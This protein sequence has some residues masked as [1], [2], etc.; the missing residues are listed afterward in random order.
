MLKLH[1]F[2]TDQSITLYWEKPRYL[3]EEY[4]FILQLDG[5]KI[6]ESPKTHFTIEKLEAAS[7]YQ[8]QL[9]LS[10]THEII[11]TS[12]TVTIHTASKKRRIDVTKAPYFAVGDGETLNTSKLQRAIDDC[13]SDSV[14]YI[15]R[16]VFMTGA[17][18]LHSDMELYLATGAVLQG[19]VH[20]QDY[21]PKIPSRFEG[22]EMKCYSSLLN[23]GDLN[24]HD[25]YNCENILIHGSGSIIGGGRQLA[26]NVINAERVEL[27]DLLSHMNAK[28]LNYET[29]DT[30]PGRVRPRLVNMSNCQNIIL[31]G[32]TLAEGACWNVHMIYSDNIITHN[33]TI[34]SEGIWNGDGWN[35]DSSTNCSIFGTTFYTGDDSIAIK[36]GK[37]PEGNMIN[38]PCKHIR[39]FD[40]TCM[41]GHGFAIGSEM[42]GGVQDVKIWD[43]DLSHT[44]YGLEIKGTKK[45]GS[46]VKDVEVR[47]CT[48]SRIMFHAVGYN[49]DG[50][51]AKHPPLFENCT[52]ENLHLL[53]EYQAADEPAEPCSAIEL[54]G[55]Q[56]TG[57]E[58][59][60]ILF[61]NILLQRLLN[62]GHQTIQLQFCQNITLQNFTV[63]EKK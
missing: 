3:P 11:R 45:R 35:P 60:N 14:V 20:P 36:S 29:E 8:I 46:Y 38:K 15:P 34:H 13:T 41:H 21:L 44:K 18:K 25:D 4:L 27:A 57:Y 52:F 10:D 48:I 50:I 61:K 58:I 23:M 12:E 47:D 37:N 43:C 19:T 55:F 30:L 9:L 2:A 62:K 40:C 33:C 1:Y 32:L 22:Y 51:G 49:D 28:E 56:E 63:R 54:M 59:K 17:L 7:T 24:R 16:G 6:G 31:S 5:K 42:S 53:G 26:E 39:I